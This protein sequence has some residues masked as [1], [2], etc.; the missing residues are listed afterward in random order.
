MYADKITD[1]MRYCLDETDR[2]REVQAAYNVEHG[3]TPEGIQKAIRDI[4]DRLRQVAEE[5]AEYT[6]NAS[7]LPRDELARMILELERQMKTAAKDLDFE[8]AALLRDQVVELRREQVG[9]GM[10]ESLRS[11]SSQ[12]R[13]PDKRKARGGRIRRGHN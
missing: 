2:R 1:S 7:D 6:V 8:R 12:S 3:I 9:D 10:P 4:G 5:P 13:R 11:M